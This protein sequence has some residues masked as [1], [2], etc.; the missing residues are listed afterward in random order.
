[1]TDGF[2]PTGVSSAADAYTPSGALMKAMVLNGAVQYTYTTQSTVLNGL[3]PDMNQGWGRM[4]LDTVLFFSTPTRDARRVRVWDKWNATGLST[5]QVDTFAVQVGAGQAF[6]V[7][8]AWTDPQA[9]ASA[10]IQLVNNLDLEIVA[11]D[12]TATYL[13]NQFSGGQ[14]VTGGTADAIN[15]VEEFFQTTPTDGTWTIRVKAT[16]IPGTPVQLYSTRQGYALV[17]TFADCTNALTAPATLSA[18][19]NANTG[20]DLSWG[21]VAGATGY[22]LYRATGNCTAAGSDF[23]FLGQSS[24]TTFTDTLVEG[25][26]SYAY[27]VR[28]VTACTEGGLSPCAS[29]TFSGNCRMYPTFAGLGSVTND[30]ATA[31]CDLALAWPAAASN[32]PLAG[33]VSYNIYRGTSP[34]FTVGAASRLVAG[35]TDTSYLD[36]SV[37]PNATYYYVVRAE[38]GTTANGGP[39]NGGNEDLNALMK[40][41]TPT[42]AT[43]TGGTWSDAGGDSTLARLVLDPPWRVTNQQNH[44]SGGSLSYHSASDGSTYPPM[45]CA[46]ANTPDI[47]LQAGAPTLTYWVRY[48]LEYQWDGV[49][50]EIS[51][52]SGGSWAV[53]TPTPAYPGVLSTGGGSSTP[54]NACGFPLTQQAFTGPDGNAALTAWT[55]YTHNLS[56]YASQTVRIRWRLSSDPGAE[57]DGFYL[58]DIQITLASVPDACTMCPNN[59]STVDV[60]PDGSL[61]LCAGSSQTLTATLTGG[62]GPFTYQW[63]RDG[64]DIG[65]ASSLTYNAG[66][67]GTHGYNCKVSG[68][69]CASAVT[70]AL[71]TQITWQAAPTFAGVVSVTNPGDATCTLNLAWSAATAICAGPVTYRVYRDTNYPFTPDE[72]N[73]IVSGLAG[74]SY[75][76]T[77]GLVSGTTYYYIVHAMDSSNG[78]EDTNLIVQ[79]GVPTGPVA[80]GTWTDDGGDT[81]TAKLALQSTWTVATTGGNN[82]PKCYATGTYGNSVCISATTPTLNVGTGGATL[83]FSSKY[84]IETGWDKGRVELSTDGGAN[85]DRLEVTTY[86]D[87]STRTAD[88]CGF[89]ANVTY[90]SRTITTPAYATYTATIPTGSAIQIRWRLSTDGSLTKT[91][92]WI[93]EISVTNVQVPGSCATG[94]A[95]PGETA[96]G[97]TFATAQSWT[98]KT[99]QTWPA[100]ATA[101]SYTLYRGIQSDLPQLLNASTDSC[102]KYTGAATGTDTI[103]EDPTGIAGGFYWYLVTGSNTGG[104]GP[105]GNATVGARTVNSSG[106]CP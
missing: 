83:T 65:G 89:P 31:M 50:T 38:D 28:A 101:T 4:L 77:A 94:S 21:S 93:D 8:L 24:T 13:G 87:N 51:T 22:Q 85:F 61:T 54:I 18:T 59:P 15:N 70:D 43:V 2:Y 60:T 96:P 81:G 55:L 19:D 66:D 62:S 3:T 79:S 41:G 99:T 86:P 95:A 12:G 64:A 1:M 100:N 91:G 34:Y 10:A 73:R 47:L 68:N 29:A 67:T 11:P 53:I 48:N 5:G 69:G 26:Y 35:V 106:G 57:F 45:T 33:T 102:T 71:S 36:G 40:S 72:G 23:H 20:V 80:T 103:T 88:D 16:A 49:V 74:T 9:S 17:A 97:D 32:C 37:E 56:S 39:A 30:T 46:S 63:T 7:T 104:E 6:K 92:W 105:A 14:S 76:D 42:A 78:A 25:G 44:T 52:N 90:F 82:G 27:M 75:S 98:D 84:D 58:D